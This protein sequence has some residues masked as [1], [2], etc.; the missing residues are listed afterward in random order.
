LQIYLVINEGFP[1]KADIV[2]PK[3]AK[4]N[5]AEIAPTLIYMGK[6]SSLRTTMDAN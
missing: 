4:A 1:S 5:G 6:P 2:L 3:R